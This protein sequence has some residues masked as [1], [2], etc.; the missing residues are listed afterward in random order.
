MTYVPI[1]LFKILDKGLILKSS[2]ATKFVIQSKIPG[3]LIKFE[4]LNLNDQL[5]IFEL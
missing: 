5:G 2:S 3:Y 4:I 1:E